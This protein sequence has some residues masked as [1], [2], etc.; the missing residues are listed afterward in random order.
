[1]DS[2]ALRSVGPL[3]RLPLRRGDGPPV[4]LGPAVLPA[5]ER[6]P[7]VVLVVAVRIVVRACMCAAALLPCEAADD[8]ALRELEQEAELQRLREVVVEERALVLDD[9]ALVPVAQA[10][11]DLALPQHLILAPE[12]PEV[13]VHRQGE[14]VADAPRALAVAA[15]EQRPQ[16]A[17]GVS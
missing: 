1:M 2:A 5:D 6:V 14:L 15:V 9:D 10:L 4:L 8:H 16:V 11:D 12:D 13:L 3:H 17:F 7:H